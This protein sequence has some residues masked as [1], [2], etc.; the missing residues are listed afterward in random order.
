M[1]K[2]TYTYHVNLLQRYIT[3][4]AVCLLATEQTQELPTWEANKTEATRPQ[5]NPELTSVQ[6][7]QMDAVIT[8]HAAVWSMEPGLTL[9][10][11]MRER[12][13]P[14]ALHPIPFLMHES[15]WLRTR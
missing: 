9:T 7:Q 1:A 5:V 4:N 10:T 11:E 12:I 15:S 3:P 8:R 2:K 13:Y 14:P 6:Q